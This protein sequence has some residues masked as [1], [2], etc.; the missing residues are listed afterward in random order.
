MN[1]LLCGYPLK[2]LPGTGD[3]HDPK[4]GSLQCAEPTGQNQAGLG[5]RYADD[6]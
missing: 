4:A 6:D 2:Q 3:E 1:T 5:M